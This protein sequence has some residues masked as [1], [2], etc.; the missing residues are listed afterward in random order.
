M[1]TKKEEMDVRLEAC[2]NSGLSQKAYY[3]PHSIIVATFSYWVTKKHQ[4]ENDDAK[5]VV[6][7]QFTNQ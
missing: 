2:Q 4:E 6:M 5:N 7:Q 1:S 3:K